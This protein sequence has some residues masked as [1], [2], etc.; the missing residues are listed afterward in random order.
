LVEEKSNKEIS[1]LVDE[2]LFEGY[3]PPLKESDIMN[4][5]EFGRVIHAEMSVIS[6]SARLGR[7]LKGATLYCTTFPCHICARHIV[8]AGI[9]RVVY[10]EPYSKSLAAKLYPDSIAVAGEVNSPGQ[11]VA[12]DHFVGIAPQRFAQ[13]FYKKKRKDKYGRAKKWEATKATPNVKISVPTYLQI[14]AG[15]SKTL[16]EI[17]RKLELPLA[18]Q[19]SIKGN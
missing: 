4:I 14:E 1:D 9:D 13:L 16:L 10:T 7:S 19:S 15:I 3:D 12:F 8:A 2:A 17:F 6:D 18:D 11:K 5:L